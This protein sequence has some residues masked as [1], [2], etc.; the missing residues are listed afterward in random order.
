[1]APRAAAH[2]AA[3]IGR[4]SGRPESCRRR[5]ATT[6]AGAAGDAAASS[7]PATDRRCDRRGPRAGRGAGV[8]ALARGDR[9]E[10]REVFSQEI[11]ALNIDAGG[12]DVAIRAGAPGQVGV[13][14]KA[15]STEALDATRPTWQ[16]SKLSMADC[17]GGCDIDY[18]VRVP[19]GVDGHR[20]HRLGRHRAGRR[21][22]D[23]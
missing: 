4:A 12:G 2:T 13:T 17:A 10:Q 23:R 9:V 19:A 22:A 1:M 21:A 7:P 5:R 6:S 8:V 15:R 14:R 20:P 11:T 16:G 3:D 18:E